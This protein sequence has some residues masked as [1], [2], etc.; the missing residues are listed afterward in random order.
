[1]TYRDVDPYLLR[2]VREIAENTDLTPDEL[3]DQMPTIIAKL[4]A[5]S[6]PRRRWHEHIQAHRPK[7]R[8]H[9][10]TAMQQVCLQ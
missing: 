2:A 3:L 5:H 8:F 1:M 6:A 9:W 4:E 10:D 7:V